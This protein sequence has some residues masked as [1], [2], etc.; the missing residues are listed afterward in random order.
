MNDRRSGAD[1]RAI[2]RNPVSIDIQWE[3]SQGRQN[4][5]IS[6]LSELGCFVLSGGMVF[7]GEAVRL[8]LPL[9]TGFNVEFRGTV[10]NHAFEIGFAVRFQGLSRA[11]RDVLFNLVSFPVSSS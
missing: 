6:D 2:A 3:G 8:F 5:T 11:Q 4:G 9:D 1:R 10:L 7:E